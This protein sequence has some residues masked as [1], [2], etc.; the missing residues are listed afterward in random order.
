[1]RSLEKLGCADEVVK[2]NRREV[3]FAVSLAV[4]RSRSASA[5]QK[6]HRIAVL[7]GASPRSTPQEVAFESRMRELGYIEGQNLAISFHTAEGHAERF[8]QIAAEAVS[9]QPE[10]IVAIGPEAGLRAVHAATTS[11]PIVMVAM[12]Y[13]P[14]ARGYIASLARPGGNIT[15]IFAEQI[16]LAAKRLQL[17]AEIVPAAK[18]LGVLSDEFAADQP[19]YDFAPAMATLRERRAGGVLVLTSPVFFRE[20]RA[21]SESVLHVGLPASF[22]LREWVEEG[23]LMSYGASLVNIRRSAADYVD[24]ILKS[25]KPA[26]LP[27]EQPTK[28]ELVINL[29]TAKALALTVP[30]SLLARADEVIE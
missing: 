28:F 21:L 30:Q 6:P 23:G 1:M 26:D 2:L 5:E 17:L 14:V 18:R 4:A 9:E 8:P 10:V 29:R 13:D 7:S 27:V 11:I 24:R 3:F 16:E 19:P 12:D 25:A 15:G 20:R 22:G